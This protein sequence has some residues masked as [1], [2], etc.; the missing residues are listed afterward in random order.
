MK[1]GKWLSLVIILFE[2]IYFNC[3][4]QKQLDRAL[5]GWTEAIIQCNKAKSGWAESVKQNKQLI[6]TLERCQG[7]KP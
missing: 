6:A 7:F 5:S 2:L 4:I 1:I 3:S